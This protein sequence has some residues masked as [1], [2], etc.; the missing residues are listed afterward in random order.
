[1]KR[2]IKAFSKFIPKEASAFSAESAKMS[3]LINI[4]AILLVVLE[5]VEEL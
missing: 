5:M 4:L 1:V 2:I 3:L